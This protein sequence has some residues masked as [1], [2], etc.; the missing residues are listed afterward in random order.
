LREALFLLTAVV[1]MVIH[2]SAATLNRM[3]Q[4]FE[5]PT[6][7]REISDPLLKTVVAAF[8]GQVGGETVASVSWGEFK[9]GMGA[10]FPDMD[11]E[12][13]IHSVRLG[14]WGAK[15]VILRKLRDM[16]EDKTEDLAVELG[17]LA[18]WDAGARACANIFAVKIHGRE[19]FQTGLLLEA[20]SGLAVKR[21]TANQQ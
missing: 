4:E 3:S 21:M 8:S 14:L 17:R 11:R 6:S 10:A 15:N 1:L 16:D 2:Q 19:S 12:Q 9:I 20:L 5:A 7:L 13:L 18:G